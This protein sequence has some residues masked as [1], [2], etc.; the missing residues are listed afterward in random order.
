MTWKCACVTWF[1]DNTALI[2]SIYNITRKLLHGTNMSMFENNRCLNQFKVSYLPRWIWSTIAQAI[3]EIHQNLQMCWLCLDTSSS[4]V[5]E[6]DNMAKR[7][8]I[9][10][11]S[12]LSWELACLFVS[13]S[14]LTVYVPF[15]I[16]CL[17]FCFL[18]KKPKKRPPPKKLFLF[19]TGWDKTISFKIT[20]YRPN[21]YLRTL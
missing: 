12:P 9:K 19:W 5:K 6:R 20:F 4:N 18:A 15:K 16:A 7:N 3:C 1:C 10:N 8:V 2:D 21:D 13:V 17:R 14:V 11:A